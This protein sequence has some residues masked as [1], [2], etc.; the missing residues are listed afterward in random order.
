MNLIRFPCQQCGARLEFAPGTETLACPYCGHTQAVPA[1][2]A[3]VE[4]L[5]FRAAL[6]R[7]AGEQPVIEA[8][9][10]Q[11]DVCGALFQFDAGINADHCPYCGAHH[12]TPG[13]STRRIKPWGLL[14]FRVSRGQAVESYKTWTRT[15]WFAPNRFKR[16]AQREDRM[17]GV[18][19]PHWTYDSD[20]TSH[21]RGERGDDYWVTESY[22]A[23]V[24]G[25]PVRRTRQ[26]RK[27]RWRPVSGT[28]RL[29]FDD[30]L[31]VAGESLPRAY[32]ERLEPWDLKALV[33][34]A[35]EY[36][37]GFRA[38]CYTVTLEQGFVRAQSIMDAAI[39][40]AIC[41]DIGGDH[42][43]IH[44]VDTRHA[45]VTFKHILLPVWLSA[46][47]YRGKV[48]R[49]VVNARTGEVQGERPYSVVKIAL[50]ALAAAGVVA[51]I[52]LALSAQ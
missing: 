8:R 32:V 10:V 33:P 42:Q 49:F 30:V 12:L 52:Y 7:Y 21:Y 26:V 34:Y 4:E 27:T 22:T 13:G 11:C 5:D 47:R 25:R 44:A 23:Y 19:V 43:R 40:R 1:V 6:E 36:L 3:E 46:Y 17:I 31:V 28:V 51:L 18:Y 14:P 2:A 20:T 24:N 35:D 37:S 15:R 38:E 50:A 45:N 16:E 9:E 41:A 48:Y 29:R 39:R